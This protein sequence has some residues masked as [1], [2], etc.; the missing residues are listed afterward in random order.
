MNCKTVSQQHRCVVFLNKE[1]KKCTNLHDYAV[2][3]LV[4]WLKV[5]GFLAN[6][7]SVAGYLIIGNL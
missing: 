7:L 2:G 5:A 6:G 1:I 3:V 4:N